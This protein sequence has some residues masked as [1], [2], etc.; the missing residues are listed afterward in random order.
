MFFPNVTTD[1]VSK[2][3]LPPPR[4]TGSHP[5]RT[6]AL[7]WDGQGFSLKEE[8]LRARKQSEDTGVTGMAG[9]GLE[10]VRQAGESS[11]GNY[12]GA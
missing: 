10:G 7:G 4:A 5:R 1:N 9:L 2:Y 3:N 11:N 6:S 8:G 12:T